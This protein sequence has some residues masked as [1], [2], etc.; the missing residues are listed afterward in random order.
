MDDDDDYD[1]DDGGQYGCGDDNSGDDGS[2]FVDVGRK[3][4]AG[5]RRRAD[6]SRR[7]R[8]ARPDRDVR[9]LV[10]GI[11][12]SNPL[13]PVVR[14]RYQVELGHV[15]RVGLVRNRQSG[16]GVTLGR[17]RQIE[18]RI[19]QPDGPLQQPAEEPRRGSRRTA[20]SDDVGDVGGDTAVRVIGQA[21]M[22]LLCGHRLDVGFRRGDPRHVAERRG[23]R[24]AGVDEALEAIA[25][26]VRAV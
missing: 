10:A 20:G 4:S 22:R 26:R 23:V 14:R 19:L 18:T 17:V 11:A 12:A 3:M 2:S 13:V 24:S 7:G 25:V 6:R 8:S 5:R 9:L 21:A 1:D 16:L 15:A